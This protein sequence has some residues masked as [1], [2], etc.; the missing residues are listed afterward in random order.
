MIAL[1]VDGPL[2]V[3]TLSRAPVNAIDEHWLERFDEVLSAVQSAPAVAVLLIR[4][5]ERAFSAGAD[6]ALMRS[7]FSSADGR[8]RMVDFVR[9]IQRV[10]A[11]L[12]TLSQVTIAEI[13]GPALGGG[14][15]LALACDLRIASNNASLGLPEA[16]L[17]LL[18]GAG[19]TQRLTRIAGEATA[20]RLIL[21]A[22][23]VTGLQA[24]PLGI[25][26]W[27]VSP[28]SLSSRARALANDIAS[29]PACAL[30]TAKRCISAAVTPGGDGY[31]LELLATARLLAQEETQSR[32]RAFLEKRR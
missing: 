17:G 15:E 22:E 30:A 9:E 26:Q 27:V 21:G 18:P 24:C 8:S 32:V 28:D 23:V 19:G 29:L 20:R 10:Y 7:R 25:V 1:D 31:E 2:A 11:R 14:L 4:S 5:S 6:L 16:R 3:T 13:A 12:E